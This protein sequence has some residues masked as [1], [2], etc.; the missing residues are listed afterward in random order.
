MSDQ[1]PIHIFLTWGKV[2]LAAL[3]D[4]VHDQLVVSPVFRA[5][6]HQVRVEEG[7]G[8]PRG[9]VVPADALDRDVDE[10]ALHDLQPGDRSRRS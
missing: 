10:P 5:Q 1:H 3:S 2:P 8:T 6:V 7:P 4:V 9:Q